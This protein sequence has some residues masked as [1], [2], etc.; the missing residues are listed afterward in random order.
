MFFWNPPPR[1][2]FTIQWMLAI[3]SLVPLSLWNSD[4]TSE[5]SRFR[6]C[7]S[8]AC[9]ILSITLLALKWA[10]L[11][12]SLNILW[13]CFFGT[14]MKT[15]LY[16][17]YGHC[18]VFQICWHIVEKAMATHSSILAWK[19]PWTEEPGRLQSMGSHSQTRLKQLTSSSSWL[20]ECST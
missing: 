12:S 15:D 7:W 13:H 11:C 14:G 16:Q 10:Q 2:F 19:I 9:R 1:A 4:C 3:W 17:S 8:L 18:W 5:N 6:C 20:I